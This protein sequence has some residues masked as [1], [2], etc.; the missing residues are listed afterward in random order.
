[1]YTSTLVHLYCT[2]EIS[3]FHLSTANAAW[4]RIRFKIQVMAKVGVSTRTQSCS[5]IQELVGVGKEFLPSE[6]PTNRAVIQQ[7][8]L[9]KNGQVS[10]H[11]KKYNNRDL[12]KD[13][14]PL[15]LKQWSK[16]NVQF[17]EPVIISE[18]AILKRILNLWET[19]EAYAWGRKTAGK[20][21][22]LSK[23]DQLMDITR[24]RHEIVLCEDESS[25]CKNFSDCKIGAHICCDCQRDSKIPVMELKWLFSQRSK[26]GERSNMQMGSKD[27]KESQRQ[28]KKIQRKTSR[29]ESLKKKIRLEMEHEKASKV[30]LSKSLHS[31]IESLTIYPHPHCECSFLIFFC[32]AG[33]FAKGGTRNS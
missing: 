5:R 22:F 33:G 7:G 25:S 20:D 17:V 23:L 9:L 31:M 6:V 29:E 26:V 18:K 4:V 13:L 24:C 32:F 16:A 10:Q 11:S 14:V 27:V 19:V 15:V 21:M 12:C 30:Q 2:L 3:C 8:I 28:S 1:M